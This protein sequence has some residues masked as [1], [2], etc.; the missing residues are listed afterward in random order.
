MVVRRTILLALALVGCGNGGQAP[1]PAAAG[2]DRRGAASEPAAGDEAAP[3][4][5]QTVPS[6]AR[7]VDLAAGLERDR[8][9]VV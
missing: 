8:K 9:S 4:S 1:E 2:D 3:R 7:K 6:R 5:P